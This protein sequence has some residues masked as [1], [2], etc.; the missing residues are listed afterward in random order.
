MIRARFL[1]VVVKV[2]EA[3]LNDSRKAKI[4]KY[5]L[6]LGRSQTFHY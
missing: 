5:Y 1:I 2:T 4:F 6:E 3:T